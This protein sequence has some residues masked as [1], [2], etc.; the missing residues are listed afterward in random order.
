MWKTLGRIVLV[1]LFWAGASV[2]A[3]AAGIAAAEADLVAGIGAGLSLITWAVAIHRM[4]TATEQ[5]QA[6]QPAVVGQRER[7]TV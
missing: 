6:T 4:Q 3:A 1:V 7:A 2:S 5:P